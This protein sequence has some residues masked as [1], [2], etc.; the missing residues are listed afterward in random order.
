MADQEDDD[1]EDDGRIEGERKLEKTT[2][3]PSSLSLSLALSLADVLS[4][5]WNLP[6]VP[7]FSSLFPFNSLNSIPIPI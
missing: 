3:A 6:S 1:G 5:K 7:P 2:C 4:A